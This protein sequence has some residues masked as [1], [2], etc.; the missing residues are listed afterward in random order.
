MFHICKFVI[1]WIIQ[2]LLTR[3][4]NFKVRLELGLILSWST[5]NIISCR[6]SSRSVGRGTLECPPNGNRKNCCRKLVLG[7]YLLSEE[8]EIPERFSK[9]MKKVNYPW[10]F[11]SKKLKI[12]LIIFK[13]FF[14]FGPKT[15]NL[16]RSFLTFPAWWKLFVKCCLYWIFLRI[17]IDFL[18]NFQEFSSYFQ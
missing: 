2:I 9:I 10:R 5:R 7:V 12:F 16:A 17:I 4:L 8:A 11:W 1:I 13:I 18:H 14:I 3:M 15:Q 6:Y